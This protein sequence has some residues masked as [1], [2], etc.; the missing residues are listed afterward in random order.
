MPRRRSPAGGATKALVFADECAARDVIRVHDELTARIVEAHAS[1]LQLLVQ[2]EGDLLARRVA[3]DATNATRVKGLGAA[4]AFFTALTLRHH[5]PMRRKHSAPI[6][7]LS[8]P[9]SVLAGGL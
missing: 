8:T 6:G 5:A 4:I 2:R 9:M 7:Y 3:R 1:A